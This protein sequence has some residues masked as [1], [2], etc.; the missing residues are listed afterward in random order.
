MSQFP[1]PSAP[2]VNGTTTTTANEAAQASGTQASEKEEIWS[3]ILKGVASSRMVPT[4]NVLILGDPQTG[5]ST[6]IHHLKYGMNPVVNADGTTTVESGIGTLDKDEEDE[7]GNELALSYTFAEVTDEEN[8]DTFARLNLYHLSLSHPSYST[9]L[10]FALN[11]STLPDSLVIIVLDWTRPWTFVEHLERWMK[12]LQEHVEGVIVKEG[13]TVAG[14]SKGKEVLD[15]MKERIE[16]YIQ[17]YSEPPAPDANGTAPAIPSTA[18]SSADQ[19]T[20][21]LGPGTLT[22]NLG[23]PIVIVCCKSDTMGSLER[24]ED[25]K[26]EQFDYILQ[27]LRAIGLKYGAALFYTGTGHPQTFPSLRSYILHRLFHTT[28]KPFPFYTRAQVIERDT[29]L[30]PAG[31][32]SWGKIKVLREGFDC[33]GVS[34]GWDVDVD[35]EAGYMEGEEKVPGA[36]GVY[37]SVIK[38]REEATQIILHPPTTWEDEQ[39]FYEKHYDTLRANDPTR[40]PGSGTQ[41]STG[42]TLPSVVGPMGLPSNSLS[43]TSGLGGGPDYDGDDVAAKLAKLTKP[44]PPSPTGSTTPPSNSGASAEV[45]VANFFQSLLSKKNGAGVAAV[46]GSASL[47]GGSAT[48]AAPAAVNSQTMQ[49]ELERLKRETK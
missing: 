48:A 30:V 32:D 24:Q 1:A 40:N 6:L 45:L 11:S 10:K 44:K 9:L 42:M 19:I 33:D 7:N 27:T 18:A 35:G 49:K 4:K 38:G 13:Q 2:V 3:A 37:E 36:R 46:G 22:K 16:H 5:K 43:L 26:E 47:N 15:E 14:W 28:A 41:I 34:R 17:T 25:Y 39:L 20:L 29:A 8:E 31:W 12:V 21:P 23:V